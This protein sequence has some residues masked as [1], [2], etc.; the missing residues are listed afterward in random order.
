MSTRT[1]LL[2]LAALAASSAAQAAP[3]V[4]VELAHGPHVK[5]RSAYLHPEGEAVVDGQLRRDQLWRG[6]VRG[7]V[8]VTAY[9][10]GGELAACSTTPAGLTRPGQ[11]VRFSCALGVP[12][13]GIT[14]LR[15]TFHPGAHDAEGAR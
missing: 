4:T 1:L 3:A 9:G 8:D 2:P 13:A 15:V 11:V 5:V 12:T 14:R 10:P 6:S 7:H